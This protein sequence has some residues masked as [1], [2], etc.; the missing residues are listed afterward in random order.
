MGNYVGRSYEN[1]V[2]DLVA[3]GIKYEQVDE[4]SDT[5]NKGTVI[6]QEPKEG[7]SFDIKTG[8]VILRVSSG[9]ESS[10]VPD[11]TGLSESEAKAK[12]ESNGFV[13]AAGSGDRSKGTAS[14]TSPS[15]GESRAK[16]STITVNYSSTTDS[17]SDQENQ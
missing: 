1:V 16:G 11:V 5:V 13:Y 15:A 14:N 9:P 2:T 7:T 6:S 8:K 17:T 12:I 4:A 10:V 3:L